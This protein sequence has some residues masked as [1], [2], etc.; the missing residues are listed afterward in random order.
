M[1]D[2]PTTAVRGVTVTFEEQKQTEENSKTR[3]KNGS[4][5]TDQQIQERIELIEEDTKFVKENEDAFDAK[6][7]FKKSKMRFSNYRSIFKENVS[8]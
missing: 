8:L 3:Q 1:G 5:E 6:I 4:N 7:K 2:I